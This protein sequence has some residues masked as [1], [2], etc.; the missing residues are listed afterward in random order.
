MSENLKQKSFIQKVEVN[1]FR[2]SDIK[3]KSL[4]MDGNRQNRPLKKDIS[5]LERDMT[6]S[7]HVSLLYVKIQVYMQD[8]CI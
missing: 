4:K 3:E 1:F 8:F 6:K 7:L 5:F 2:I